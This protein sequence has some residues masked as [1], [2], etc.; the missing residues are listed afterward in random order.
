MTR[1]F[2]ELQLA[3]GDWSRNNFG[4]QYSKDLQVELR[5]LNPLLGLVE[6]FGEFYEAHSDSEARKDAIS[7]Q[8]IYLMDFMSRFGLS[9]DE[10]RYR[11]VFSDTEKTEL[12]IDKHIVVTCELCHH[13]LKLQQGI[14][15]YDNFTYAKSR[16]EES[17]YKIVIWLETFSQIHYGVRTLDLANKTFDEIVSKRDWKKNKEQG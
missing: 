15:G 7:D 6:E 9:F 14:R 17:C 4:N 2:Q 8:I 3:V 13:V 16:I 1:T 5:Y 11:E 10:E 12:T